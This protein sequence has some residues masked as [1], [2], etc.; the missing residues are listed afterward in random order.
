VFADRVQLGRVFQ[1][2]LS[3]AI[4][5]AQPDH[6]PTIAVTARRLATSWEF[7][8]TDDGIGVLAEDR[9]RIFE[10]FQRGTHDRQRGP[11]HGMGLAICRTIVERHGG[12]IGVEKTPGSGARFSFIIPDRAVATSV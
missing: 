7:A 6:P 12:R 9:N 1:N 4:Q 10:L 8:V 11:G 2:L 3:N 5:A